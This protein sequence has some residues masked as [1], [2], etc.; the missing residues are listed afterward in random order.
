[1][2]STQANEFVCFTC[3][4]TVA[5]PCA[6]WRRDVLTQISGFGLWCLMLLR[7]DPGTRV[8]LAGPRPPDAAHVSHVGIRAELWREVAAVMLE[9]GACKVARCGEGKDSDCS[10]GEQTTSDQAAVL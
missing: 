4:S 3:V 2:L 10:V 8:A 7:R 1:M 6:P 5:D 9:E